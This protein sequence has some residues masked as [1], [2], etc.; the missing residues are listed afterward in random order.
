[1]AQ[2]FDQILQ[3]IDSRS[4]RR[5]IVRH[6]LGS[7]VPPLPAVD[8][9]KL[10]LGSHPLL[11][12]LVVAIGH[13]IRTAPLV[14]NVVVAILKPLLVRQAAD[15]ELQLRGHQAEGHRLGSE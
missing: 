5:V 6:V 12:G 8:W 2:P 9:S 1:M 10:T 13:P 7:K 3:L 15:E 11:C 14:P 4:F